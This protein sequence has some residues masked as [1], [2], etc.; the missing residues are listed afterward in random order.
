M[1]YFGMAFELLYID[2]LYV[3]NDDTPYVLRTEQYNGIG[4]KK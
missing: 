2:D 3:R 1:V 4:G